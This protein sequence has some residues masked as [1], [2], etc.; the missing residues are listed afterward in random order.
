[1]KTESTKDIL[2]ELTVHTTR[3]SGDVE[4]IKEKVNEIN[5]HLLRLNGRVV[6]TEKQIYSIKGIGATLVFIIGSVL[7][8][9]GI[10]K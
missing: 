4:H 10:D 2:T 9:L 6:E 8:W 1:M 7:T 5:E 3:I